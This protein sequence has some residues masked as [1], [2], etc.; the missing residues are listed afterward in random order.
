MAASVT[1][2]IPDIAARVAQ[3]YRHRR[4]GGDWQSEEYPVLFAESRCHLGGTRKWFLCPARGCGRRVAVLYGGGI[5]ACRECH[6][7][8][9]DSQREKPHD[10]AL[11][12]LQ[13]LHV[14]LGG[15]GAVGDGLPF[16][17]KGMHWKTY[18]VLAN[19]FRR[20]DMAMDSAAAA[21]FGVVS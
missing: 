5:F 18:R 3:V 2:S 6:Q 13:K 15:S 20:L 1:K 10:R 4:G 8:A 17:P 7:L 11:S 9:Y 19:R 21:Y 12:R 16:K 14:R